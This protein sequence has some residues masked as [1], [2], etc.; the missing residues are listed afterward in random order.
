M[1]N[2]ILHHNT[3][4]EVSTINDIHDEYSD[5]YT[6]AKVLE[7]YI[8]NHTSHRILI[9]P[10][11]GKLFPYGYSCTCG[12]D[13]HPDRAYVEITGFNETY[14]EY[15]LFETELKTLDNI[16]D[17]M[18]WGIIYQYVQYFN[19]KFNNIVPSSIEELKSIFHNMIDHINERPEHT[20]I[21][22]QF[23]HINTDYNR[24]FYKIKVA[25]TPATYI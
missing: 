24:T 25:A 2:F 11:C 12:Y 16:D 15:I 17:K 20:G 21:S 18:P 23:F 4:E 14:Q 7:E 22:N 6:Y 8:K 13:Y 9:C 19:I 3:P 5:L 1:Y 10:K